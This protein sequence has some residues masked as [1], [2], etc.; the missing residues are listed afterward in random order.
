MQLL[1]ILTVLASTEAEQINYLMKLGVF[2]LTDE[3]ALEFDDAYQF[4][5]SNK[6]ERK[7]GNLI[8]KIFSDKLNEIDIIFSEM[9]NV[10]DNIFWNV[11]SLN[12]MEW[13]KVRK[14]AKEALGNIPQL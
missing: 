5:L 13:G 3:F 8:N 7:E 10:N 1:K 11:S 6:E 14:L 9:S 12:L 2:P 4:F